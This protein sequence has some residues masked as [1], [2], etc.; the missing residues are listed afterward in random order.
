MPETVLA[1]WTNAGADSS[2]K[3]VIAE[4]STAIA[5]ALN[6]QTQFPA[7]GAVSTLYAS[8]N[9]AKFGCAGSLLFEFVVLTSCT[10]PSTTP[11]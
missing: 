3:Q 4:S 6:N 1:D 9:S 2:R 8:S 5:G 11:R 10:R 7:S